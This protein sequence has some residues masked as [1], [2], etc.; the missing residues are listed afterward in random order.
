M[1]TVNIISVYSLFKKCLVHRIADRQTTI[2]ICERRIEK[3]IARQRLVKQVIAAT[4]T[5]VRGEKLLVVNF[6]NR[7][8]KICFRGNEY[9]QKSKCI[10][11]WGGFYSVRLV[12][13]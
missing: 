11:V 1:I 13:L 10:V 4:I 9:K 12:L 8:V 6:N 7:L 5:R 2:F 3:S